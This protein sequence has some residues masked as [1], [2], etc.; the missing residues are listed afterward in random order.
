MNRLEMNTN[1]PE[2]TLLE[3]KY[4]RY[5]MQLGYRKVFN[6]RADMVVMV[7][8]NVSSDMNQLSS[9]D[10]QLGG[11]VLF[12]KVRHDSLK[13]KYGLYANAEFFGPFIVP[14]IGMDWKFSRRIRF[15]GVLPARF[16]AQYK[17]NDHWRTGL[18]FAAPNYSYRLSDSPDDHGEPDHISAYVHS[19]K[20][21]LHGYLEYYLTG[22]L[23]VQA[24]AG[25]TVFRRIRLYDSED[26]FTLSISG[27]GFGGRRQP[28][29]EPAY[30]DFKDGWVFHF[31]LAYR[32][33]LEN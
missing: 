20:N 29:P 18:K 25:Y 28:I 14:L 9:E 21:E 31:R 8:P 19:N 16:T 11:L 33:S 15:F 24:R 13:W 26:T 27:I 30:R 3:H 7:I 10:Y 17:L 12:S 2:D 23:V 4:F 32:F 5:R 6:D 1:I 22:G